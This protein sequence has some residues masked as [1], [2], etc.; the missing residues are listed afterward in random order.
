LEDRWLLSAYVVTSA[1]DS[2]AGTLRDAIA[3]ANAAGSTIAEIDFNIGTA[4]S[5]QTIN[6]LSQLPALNAP[7]AVYINGLSQGGAGNS[8]PLIE[9]NGSGAGSGS[10]GLLLSGA[11][12]TVSGLII[13]DFNSNGIEVSG[14]NNVIGGTAAG[15]GNVLSG[16]SNDG[17]LID[18]AASGV[19]VEGNFM[20]TDVTGTKSVGNDYDGIE[21]DGSNNTIGGTVAGA[22]NVISGNDVH[23]SGNVGGVVIGS[24][25]SGVAVQGNYI[26][27]DVTGEKAIAN[28]NGVYVAGNTNTIGGTTSGA[29]NVISGNNGDGVVLAGTSDSGNQVLGNF[30]GT[31]TAGSAELHNGEG[32]YVAASN[33]TIGGTTSGARNIISGNN[34]DGVDIGSAASGVAVQG[35]YIGTDVTGASRVSNGG[36][37]VAVAGSNDTI[38]GTA[39]GA[40]NVI[41]GSLSV[42][43]GVVIYTPASGV[44]VQGNYIGTNAA[45]SAII[46]NWDGIAVDNSNSTIGGT[47]AGAGNVISGNA[48]DGVWLNASDVTVQGNSIGT[49]AA[50]NAL[51]GGNGNAGIEVAVSD[52]TIGGTTSGARNIISGNA[53]SYGVVVDSGVSGVSVQ[54]NYIGTDV[55]GT[56]AVPNGIGV[57]VEGSNNTIGGTATGAGNV[58]SGNNARGSDGVCIDSGVSGV[59]VQGNYIGTDATGTTAVANSIGVD[60][61]GPNNT[62]GGTIAG[63][64]NVISGNKNDGVVIDS[65]ASGVAVEGNYIGTDVTGA[66]AI[67]NVNGVYVAGNTN[68][69]GGTTSGARNIISG[70][71]T[72]GVLIDSDA[73]GVAVQGNSIG[74]D[75]SGAA[76]GNGHYGVNTSGSNNTIGGS[77]A[78]AGNSIAYNSSGGVL[79]STGSGNTIRLDSIFANGSTHAGP[80]ITLSSG[81]NNNLAAPALSSATI[82]GSTL[83]V[84]GSFTAPAA[85]VS[86]VLDFFANLAGDAEG[87][88]YL[89]SLTMT[90]AKTGNMPFTFTTT[91]TVTGT[92]PL[93]TA[94]LTDA[95][96]DTSSF[97]NG[98]TASSPPSSPPPASPP[99]PVL[100]VPP[101]LAFFNSLFGGGIETVNGNGT[102]TVTDSLFG[103][104]VLVSTFD[105]S[106]NLVSVV[107]FGINIPSWVW[108]V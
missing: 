54:G 3:Q 23:G 85:N 78:S 46:G 80:G 52:N 61:E 62:I 43:A 101:L 96:G 18:S 108:F 34:G 90:P 29:R 83:T 31:N 93:I 24:S 48:N 73:T 36:N 11:G 105:S 100:N 37:G 10:D 14:A 97:S 4:G 32:V 88:I 74:T 47:A 22:R 57:I 26:G 106:G 12:N 71:S 76:L 103:I 33:N 98:V 63:A 82:S 6:L 77:V 86:Y 30:I 7:N 35:N 72:D 49:N 60:V 1:A 95:S 81:A 19:L 25:A 9:L 50:G 75:V 53:D 94:T 38:G 89:G 41:S 69:I 67:A 59:A 44:T 65:S 5:A 42:A 15:A 56:T 28:V 13:E 8:V 92:H 70:N 27:T 68:T 40:R 107:W 2:G 84:Q 91:T 79:V 20:G 64:G 66:K 99:L 104:P 39:A 58:I 21:V 55:T 45:G 87:K 17:L 51:I 16:N 102:V